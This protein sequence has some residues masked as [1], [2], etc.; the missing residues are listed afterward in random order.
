M[1]SVNGEDVCLDVNQLKSVQA[2]RMGVSAPW[3]ALLVPRPF[4]PGPALPQLLQG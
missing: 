4:V 3:G 1:R 2:G